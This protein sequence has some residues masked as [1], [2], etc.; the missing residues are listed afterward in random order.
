MTDSDLREVFRVLSLSKD[1]LGHP[2]PDGPS[3]I[4]AGK[5]SNLLK[6]EPFDLLC[7]IIE[8]DLAIFVAFK[9]R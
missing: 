5:V 3:E 9:E 8:R 2:A 4:E 6:A 7:G 1:D